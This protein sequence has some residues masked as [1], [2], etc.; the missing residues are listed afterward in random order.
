M[1]IFNRPLYRAIRNR[2]VKPFPNVQ[3]L[4]EMVEK[5]LIDRLEV[6]KKSFKK[7]L[8]IGIRLKS[9]VDSIKKR[10]PDSHLVLCDASLEVLKT[11]SSKLPKVVLDE[12]ALPFQDNSFDLIINCLSMHMINDVPKALYSL[13]QSLEHDGLFLS[14]LFGGHSLHELRHSFLEADLAFTEGASP[15]V[16][17]FIELHTA[18]T[19]LY[20][21]GYTLPVV[22][23]DTYTVTY[24][25]MI[26]L[27]HDLK[28]MGEGN[29]LVNRSPRY[30]TKQ[31]FQEAE[32]L[33]REKYQNE[34]QRLLATFEILY[35]TGW[36]PHTSQQQPLKPG[37]ATHSLAEALN[38]PA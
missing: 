30:M 38:Q 26:D 23:H 12:D 1:D 10:Y 32:R 9:T 20:T 36:T 19:L 16:A 31:F 14:A 33:Y 15:R 21:S 25:S 11:H 28:A 24:D 35:L 5:D 17:P 37:S 2:S 3:F 7:I 29:A 8:L 6:V 13:H 18:T 34:D 4:H 22:D 27:L